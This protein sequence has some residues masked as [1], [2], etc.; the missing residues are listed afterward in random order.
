MRLVP[1]FPYVEG[2]EAHELESHMSRLPLLLISTTCLALPVTVGCSSSPNNVSIS[3]IRGNLTPEVKGVSETSYD[4]ANNQA[5]IENI[6]WR[7]AADDLDRILLLD[8]PSILSRYPIVS[9]GH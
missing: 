5:I 6:Q 8:Q 9:T 4:Q 1:S 2:S 7:E 3:S